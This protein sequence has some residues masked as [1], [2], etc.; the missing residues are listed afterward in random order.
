M[1]AA[2]NFAEAGP[3]A[4]AFVLAVGGLLGAWPA[5]DGAVALIMQW[6]VGNF[7]VVDVFPNGIARPRKI[8]SGFVYGLQK[9]C[10]S[11][12]QTIDFQDSMTFLNNFTELLWGREQVRATT[13]TRQ[14]R[15]SLSYSSGVD[16]ANHPKNR[17]EPQF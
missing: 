4:R 14:R 8:K 1:D 7:V 11:I 12:N 2:L 17:L 13:L 16:T 3:A 9:R 10:F 15:P 5:A 6:I